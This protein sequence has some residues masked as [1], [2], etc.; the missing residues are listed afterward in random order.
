[1]APNLSQQP[2]LPF[3]VSLAPLILRLVPEHR[4]FD[5]SDSARSN[6]GLE[7]F[8]SNA[9]NPVLA[10]SAKA[11]LTWGGLIVLLS[12]PLAA[13]TVHWY[14]ILVFGVLLPIVIGLGNRLA[15]SHSPIAPSRFADQKERELLEALTRRGE[16]TPTS[17]A[18]ETSLTVSEADRM[19][20]ELTQK[21][22]LEVRAS[23]G[24]L[25]FSLG[26]HKQELH[27]PR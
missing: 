6:S 4:R 26:D 8:G 15:D 5:E 3:P 14:L 16:L 18:M 24:R 19:L 1:M 12:L 21:G 17:A 13:T 20:T 9:K 23:G 25:S 22:H 10:V 2:K 11:L 7:R 27:H